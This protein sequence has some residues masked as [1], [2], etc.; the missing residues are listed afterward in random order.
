MLIIVPRALSEIVNVVSTDGDVLAKVHKQLLCA[1]SG[2]LLG[3]LNNQATGTAQHT[4]STAPVL[5]LTLPFHGMQLE[6][7]AVAK[8]LVYWLYYHQIRIPKAIRDK[9]N[10]LDN[11]YGFLCKLWLVSENWQLKSFGNN[12]VDCIY[13]MFQVN[14]YLPYSVINFVYDQTS[15]PLSAIRKL[16]VT[17]LFGLSFDALTGLGNELP[18]EF[19]ADLDHW[20]I[21]YP[22][23]VF[24]E[25][26]LELFCERF[27]EHDLVAGE[28]FSPCIHLKTF[29]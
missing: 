4:G 21:L 27:H 12:V 26:M 16:F 28:Q 20:Q 18:D 29:E 14:G 6:E 8:S 13:G 22:N 11:S 23:E 2:Y 10:D 24:S 17:I 9:S 5:S 1:E 15:E 7:E 19:I 25:T 3:L